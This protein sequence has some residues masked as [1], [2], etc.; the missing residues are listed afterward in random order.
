MTI[1][2]LVTGALMALA[3]RC[4]S[5]PM[6]FAVA[7]AGLLTLVLVVLFLQWTPSP[8][9]VFLTWALF[10]FVAALSF[11]TYAALAPQFPSELTGRL[12]A[13]LTLAWM[14]G[15][16]VLQTLYVFLLMAVGWFFLLPH[17]LKEQNSPATR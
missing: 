14:L 16:F 5:A 6:E 8:L 11:V 10:G 15:A 13:C 9:M 12:N 1:S 7:T 4:G 17:L 3:K 2:G